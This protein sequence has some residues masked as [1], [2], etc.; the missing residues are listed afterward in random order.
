MGPLV[1][2]PSAL[3]W[4]LAGLSTLGALSVDMYLPAAS[5]VAL[6][7]NASPVQLQQVLSSFLVGISVMSLCLGALVDRFGRRPTILCT[8]FMFVLASAGCAQASTMGELIAYRFLQGMAG[9]SGLVIGLVV[10]RDLYDD[11]QAQ[12]VMSQ[13]TACYVMALVIAPWVGGWLYVWAGWQAIFIA[14]AAFGLLL[15]LLTFAML[16]ESLPRTNRRSLEWRDLAG[17]YRQILRNP[18]FVLWVLVTN[19]PFNGLFLYVVA[20]PEFLGRHLGLAPTEFFWFFTALMTGVAAG[21]LLAA[22]WAGRLGAVLQVGAGFIVMASM[23]TLNL[24]LDLILGASLLASAGSLMVYALGWALI[25]PICALHLAE[26]DPLR[27]GLIAS[28][29]AMTGAIGNALVAGLL[30]PWVMDT[31]RSLA[32]AS[33]ILMGLG[34]VAWLLLRLRYPGVWPERSN[35]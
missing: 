2:A 35:V 15:L 17:G 5:G 19:A 1:S 21:S 30:A 10:V 24:A 26:L 25:F 7:L 31:T 9:G 16:P 33:F 32:L 20:S 29:H 12:K 23:V 6:A 22:R 3:P 14:L 34:L 11:A 4:L 13:A 18:R 28:L 27:R 8:T